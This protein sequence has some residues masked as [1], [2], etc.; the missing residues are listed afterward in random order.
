MRAALYRHARLVS[1]S[2]V[3]TSVGRTVVALDRF[4]REQLDAVAVQ[5]DLELMRLGE[6][7]RAVARHVGLGRAQH[8][9]LDHVLAVAWEVILEESASTCAERQPF[10]AIVLRP[11]WRN[12]ERL[13]NRRIRRI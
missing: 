7:K 6:T 10:L 2:L 8:Q 13:R 5:R 4:E 12:L 1:I 11:L 3:H 9:H